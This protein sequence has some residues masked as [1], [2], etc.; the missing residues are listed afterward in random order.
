MGPG[1]LEEVETE[2]RYVTD[3]TDRKVMIFLKKGKRKT[4]IGIYDTEKD[5][6]LFYL[7]ETGS[8]NADGEPQYRMCCVPLDNVKEVVPIESEE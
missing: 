2:S 4:I 8:K 3:L 6:D 1:I 5:G 7:Q